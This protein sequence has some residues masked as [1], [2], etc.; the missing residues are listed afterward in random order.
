MC[1]SIHALDTALQE[2]SLKLVCVRYLPKVHA[3][4]KLLAGSPSTAGQGGWQVGW[5]SSPSAPEV[6]AAL[7]AS[8]VAVFVPQE[9]TRRAELARADAPPLWPRQALLLRLSAA[10]ARPA[11]GSVACVHGAAPF[12][13]LSPR[14]FRGLVSRGVIAAV[15]STSSRQTPSHASGRP[16]STSPRPEGGPPALLLSDVQSLPGMEGASVHGEGAPGHGEGVGDGC[17]ECERLRQGGESG[18]AA[19]SRTWIGMLLPPLV[20]R[21]AHAEVATVAPVAQ[22]RAALTD[23]LP[24]ASEETTS[25]FDAGT[26]TR[27]RA[28]PCSTPAPADAL[29][30]VRRSVVALS[31]A[32]G[33]ASG[34]LV[35]SRGPIL[36]N[37]H[38]FHPAPKKQRGDGAPP[39]SEYPPVRAFVPGRDQWVSAQVLHVFRNG[40]DLAVLSIPARNAML[41]G[42][43]LEP[44][45]PEAGQRVLSVGYPLLN[46]VGLRARGASA[47]SP[48]PAVSR[49]IVA[50]VLACALPQP[51]P[52]SRLEALIISTA[53]VHSGASGGALVSARTGKLV[54]LVTSNARLASGQVLPR[55][56]F[57]LPAVRFRD[58][59]EAAE[60]EGW[61]RVRWERWDVPDPALEEVWAVGQ[62]D[63][64]E[65]KR[66]GG[67]FGGAKPPAELVRLLDE[68]ARKESKLRPSAHVDAH[69][70]GLGVLSKL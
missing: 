34:V 40:L 63:R 52:L 12:A 42:L 28:S 47:A 13:A 33:W 64:E 50:S 6:D 17:A 61:R 51:G 57:S 67:G 18:G 48:S 62:G 32:S 21:S 5:Q 41:P 23:L 53:T 10:A 20:A 43:E 45:A 54:G 27:L 69:V 26:G 68:A 25:A 29:D 38:L 7:L 11:T 49:G 46:P 70:G 8:H 44:V 55:V 36:T 16:F 15:L 24:E 30:R 35:G 31:L 56:N 39:A 58:M 4:L 60:G 37:A 9:S 3:S 2:T 65:E 19:R 1:C 66:G 59:L 14:H 22:L